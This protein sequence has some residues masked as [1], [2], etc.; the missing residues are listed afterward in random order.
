MPSGSYERK[1]RPL[2]ERFWSKVDKRG[3]EEC[4]PWLAA[5]NKKGYGVISSGGHHGAV[6]LARHVAYELAFGHIL[7]GLTVRHR[8]DNRLCCNPGHLFLICKKKLLSLADRFWSKVD[9]RN[10]D[11]CWEWKACR[12]FDGRGQIRVAGKNMLAPR[13]AWNLVFGEIP[14][15]IHVCHKCDNPPCCNPSHLFLGSDADN[16]HDCIAKQRFVPPPYH[17]RGERNPSA[18]LTASQVREIRSRFQ[19]RSKSCGA[20]ALGREYGVSYPTILRA[21]RRETWSHVDS[22]EDGQVS[23]CGTR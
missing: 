20:R 9:R 17:G 8:C 19:W 4:W 1:L 14:P 7:P 12:M 21:V 23:V 18:K 3:H 11:E 2:S 6:L 16:V 10:S 5:K 22:S 15:G 13:L